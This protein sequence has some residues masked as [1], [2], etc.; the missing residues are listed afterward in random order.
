MSH[1]L[2]IAVFG[3]ACAALIVLPGCSASTPKSPAATPTAT[4]S[5]P[6]TSAAATSPSATSPSATSPQVTSIPSSATPGSGSLTVTITGL[7]GH[8]ALAPGG[9]PLQFTVTLRNATDHTYRNITPLVSIGHCTCNSSPAEMAPFGTLAERDPATGNWRPVFYDAEGTGM[10]Y[11]LGNIVQQPAFTLRPAA[12]ASFTF[13]VGF[14]AKQRTSLH[15]GQT[16]I[17]VTVVQ[18]PGRTWIGNLPAA[19][20]PVIFLTR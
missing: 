4:A 15:G 19:S 17:N 14:T 3:S 1:R 18:L 10:D 16:A 8:P 2:A 11:I 20:V 5:P 7:P 9:A 12:T 6:A 13:R